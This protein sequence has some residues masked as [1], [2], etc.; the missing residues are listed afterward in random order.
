MEF[1]LQAE[2]KKRSPDGG[3]GLSREE[4]ERKAFVFEAFGVA[5]RETPV[6]RLIEEFAAPLCDERSDDTTGSLVC[7]KRGSGGGRKILLEAHM[8]TVGFIA[9]HVDGKGFVRFSTVGVPPRAYLLGRRVLFEEGT[10]GVIG[11]EK[12]EHEKNPDPDRMF[13]DIGA[14]GKGDALK[15]VSIGEACTLYEPPLATDTLLTG[16]GLNARVGCFILLTAMESVRA[17]RD[18]IYYLFSS[19][20]EVG[21]RG[22]RTSVYGIEPDVALSVGAAAA[23]DLPRGD[24]TSSLRMGGGAAITVM[25]RNV[26]VPRRI[27]DHLESLARG[28]GIPF[29]REVN[30]KDGSSA[31]SVQLTR[32]GVLTGAL[33]VPVRYGRTAG[34]LCL[35]EDVKACVDLATLFCESGTKALMR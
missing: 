14:E 10:V 30:R 23:S 19:Q 4:L 29:Q 3:G 8:D 32:G 7:L 13:I 18:D 26:I 5:G 35:L 24:R 20:G 2:G 9:T 17:P 1:H 21:H 31:Q 12:E 6:R 34:E 33:S 25:D 22:A 28:A 27:V 15:R 16:A 11:I